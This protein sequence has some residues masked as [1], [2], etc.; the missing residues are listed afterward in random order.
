[1]HKIFPINF[2]IRTW[3]IFL[4]LPRITKSIDGIQLMRLFARRWIARSRQL[5]SSFD[6]LER[7]ARRDIP[8]IPSNRCETQSFD[9]TEQKIRYSLDCAQQV[10]IDENESAR[11]FSFARTR[12]WEDDPYYLWRSYK[13]NCHWRHKWGQ[14]LRSNLDWDWNPSSSLKRLFKIDT[15]LQGQLSL[16]GNDL[17]VSIATEYED[18]PKEIRVAYRTKDGEIRCRTYNIAPSGEEQSKSLLPDHG[19]QSFGIGDGK[20]D[21]TL[22]YDDCKTTCAKEKVEKWLEATSA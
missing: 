19:T 7:E 12:D 6:D 2:D 13:H 9:L 15:P 21:G 18:L 5:L 16:I 8:C 17:E 3:P 10:H 20:D 22:S 4:T 11:E 14:V 1:M